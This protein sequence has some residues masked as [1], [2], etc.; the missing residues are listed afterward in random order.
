[1]KNKIGHQAN[2][3]INFVSTMKKKNGKQT[4]SRL[5]FVC[6]IL[7]VFISCKKVDQEIDRQNAGSGIVGFSPATALLGD[8][9]LAFIKIGMKDENASLRFGDAVVQ[10]LEK[11]PGSFEGHQVEAWTIIVPR[12][13]PFGEPPAA[14]TVNGER[15]P[16]FYG[17]RLS[18]PPVLI[19]G[20]VTVSLYAGRYREKEYNDCGYQIIYP[21]KNGTLQESQFGQTGLVACSKTGRSV[22]VVD[23]YEPY[24]CSGQDLEN[25]KRLIRKIE[26]GTVSTIAGG[27]NDPNGD[28]LAAKLPDLVKGLA[29]HPNGLL[30]L[31]TT[32]QNYETGFIRSRI[33]SIDP[34]SGKIT[35]VAGGQMDEGEYYGKIKDGEGVNAKLFEPGD[36]SFDKDGNLYF[37]DMAGSCIRKLDTKNK[38]TTLFG[39]VKDILIGEETWLETDYAKRGHDDGY[40]NQEARFG[41]LT[42][43]ATA[44]NGK[45]YVVDNGG[46]KFGPNVREI[47]PATQ[48]VATVIGLPQGVRGKETGSF[49]EVSGRPDGT[50][51]YFGMDTDFDGNLLLTLQG[52]GYAM[53]LLKVDLQFETVK[54]IAGGGGQT[55]PSVPVAGN[56]A[57]LYGEAIA[58][59]DKGSLYLGDNLNSVIRKIE[60]EQ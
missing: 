19:E 15:M 9:V 13:A 39:P 11:K 12:N 34:S 59:D 51:G 48:E 55:D 30:Y 33:I 42:G 24:T 36:L 43:I 10:V 26:N 56:K 41:T 45:V 53:K 17:I 5:F 50:Q 21:A 29:V 2:D 6:S 23:Y 49:K 35:T 37:L 47:N 14:L 3:V 31:S 32:D 22:Y 40:G 7:L 54:L 18:E 27:G 46:D 38:V 16:A 60:R 44:G 1:M 8:T 28:G 25:T 58:F 4:G 20:K 57:I 52:D